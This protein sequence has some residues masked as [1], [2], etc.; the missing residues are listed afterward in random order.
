MSDVGVP[1]VEKLEIIDILLSAPNNFL[2]LPFGSP[3]EDYSVSL[4]T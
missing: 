2:P 3:S 1:V 4:F